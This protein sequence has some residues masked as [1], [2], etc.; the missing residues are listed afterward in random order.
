[1]GVQA[2]D[3]PRYP[4]GPVRLIVP[5]VPG[6][7]TDVQAPQTTEDRASKIVAYSSRRACLAKHLGQNLLGMLTQLWWQTPD[8]GRRSREALRDRHGNHATL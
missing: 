2:Q 1:M 3:T 7:A 8:A 5:H 6:G 4:R